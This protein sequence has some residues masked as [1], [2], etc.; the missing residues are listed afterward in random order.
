MGFF[1]YNKRPRQAANVRNKPGAAPRRGKPWR[2]PR[3]M[4]AALAFCAVAATAAT[5]VWAHHR[6]YLCRDSRYTLL[7]LDIEPGV[8]YTPSALADILQ[9][10]KG[11][12]IFTV[13]DIAE[14]R[15]FLLQAGHAVKEVSLTRVLPDRL[16]VRTVEREPVARIAGD[17]HLLVDGEGVVFAGGWAAPLPGISGAGNPLEPG[18]RLRNMG[19]AAAVF[20]RVLRATGVNLP[21]LNID[22][23]KE[24]YI[25]LTL[26]NSR[27]ILLAW[28]GIGG[29]GPGGEEALR[30][31]LGAVA[32]LVEN[33]PAGRSFDARKKSE[34]Y[35]Q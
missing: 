3:W 9:L 29:A 15:R 7:H 26:P 23:S 28:E 27:K 17:A 22:A 2:P 8:L 11:H 6:F 31:H 30:E 32:S 16:V 1:T 25:V 24:D 13:C 10:E 20:A 21:V 18:A 12:N 5:G 35:V 4:P 33:V 14:R 34:I 19:L